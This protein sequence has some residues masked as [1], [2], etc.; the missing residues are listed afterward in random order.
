MFVRGMTMIFAERMV[1]HAPGPVPSP[2]CDGEEP[3]PVVTDPAV[4]PISPII[5]AAIAEPIRTI[6]QPAIVPTRSLRR[7]SRYKTTPASTETPEIVSSSRS[8]SSWPAAQAGPR[9]R[10]A[11]GLRGR[12]SA[13]SLACQAVMAG[14]R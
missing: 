1:V 9:P 7:H 8:A 2:G 12:C 3:A 6:I 11:S 14:T 4:F 5:G 13:P 10:Q